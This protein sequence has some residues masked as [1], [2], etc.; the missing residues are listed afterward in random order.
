M[1][2]EEEEKHSFASILSIDPYNNTYIRSVSSFL[3]EIN[4][5]EYQKDQFAISYLNTQGFIN[6]QISIT[7]NIPEE[8]LHDAI[9]SKVYDD[10][11][12]DQ[13]ITYQIQYIETFNNLDED[14]RNFH[15]FVVDPLIID[16]TYSKTIEKIKYLDVIIPTPLLLKS[17]YAKDIIDTGGV[18]CFIYFQEDDAFVTVY[19]EKEYIYTKSIKYSFIQ[20]HERFCEL[21]GE[22]VDYEEFIDFLSTAN[23]KETN[24]DFKEFFIRLFKEIFANVNDILTYIK[25]AFEIEKINHVYIGLQIPSIT[26]LD[27]LAEV[28]L[29]IKSS[30]FE[31]DYGFESS[32]VHVDQIHSLMHLYTMLPQGDKYNCNFTT[33]FRPPKFTK[34][35]SGKLIILTAASFALA[36]FY[37]VTYWSLTFAQSYQ[38]DLLQQEYAEVHNIK[39]TREATIKNKEAD[40]EKM[41]TLLNKEQ[42]NYNDKKN[43]LIKIHDVKVNYPMKAKLLVL[44]TKD[45]NK[46]NVRVESLKYAQDEKNKTFYFDLVSSN[47]KKITNLVEYLTS[48]HEGT[49]HFSLNK[50]YFDEDEKKY[51]SELKVNLL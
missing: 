38:Y 51:F 15:V 21:Y 3:N 19:N 18:H 7:K 30:N 24:S 31:F 17:L 33:Y 16:E 50:I 12:L 9:S 27:E 42:E 20:M 49:F 32:D 14:N 29:S 1:S 39:I 26:K 36:F 2:K 40:K 37:P 13:A 47:D 46:Y 5:P 28:E 10:L 43:T 22:R 48:K 4:S 44:F 35:A 25:R 45:L 23:L 41:L 8:D 11:A 6:T 34:R